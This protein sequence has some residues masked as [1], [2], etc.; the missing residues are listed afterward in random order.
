VRK[1]FVTDFIW[2]SVQGNCIYED[3][4]LLGTAIARPCIA[5]R[6]V[7]VAIREGARYVAHGATGKGN[8]QIRFELTAYALNP[9][10]EILAPWRMPEFFQRFEGRQALLDYAAEKNIPV[11]VTKKAPW[12]MDANLMHI[13]YESGVLEDPMMRAPKGIFKMT[14]DIEDTPDTPAIIAIDFLKGVPV[15][16]TNL[17]DGTT[18][19]DALALYTC[20]GRPAFAHAVTQAHTAHTRTPHGALLFTCI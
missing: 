9:N 14:R 15:K 8:D 18:H 5:K 3:R 16:V 1:E 6:Q 19:S 4:Y 20:V 17:D 13:S 11:S 12:S 10:L 7:E 2:P